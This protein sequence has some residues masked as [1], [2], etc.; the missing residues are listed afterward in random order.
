M[1]SKVVFIVGCT[2]CG[3]GTLTREL[4]VR[5]GGEIVSLDSM[6]VYRRMDIGTAKPSREAREAIPHHLIDL[7]EPSEE[8]TVARYLELAETALEEIAARER[9]ILVV[10]GTFL[11][12]KALTS[13]MFDG[14]GADP[15]VRDRL[16]QEAKDLGP[17]AFHEQLRKVDPVAAERIHHNDQRRVVRALEIY[18]LTGSTISSLQQQW[19]VSA[20][21][22][23]FQLLGLRRDKEDQSHR[24]NERVRR[25]IEA[26]LVDEVRGLM[27][28]PEPLSAT[29]K[30]AVGYAEIIQHLEGDVSLADAIEMIKINTRQ[31]AKSQ[32]TWLKRFDAIDWVDLAPDATAKQLAD[33]LMTSSELPWS[34]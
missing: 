30:K 19:K 22:R 12:L 2:G 14:P 10:G 9:P 20:P 4:A 3:K 13:G 18:E 16:N 11:Y 23:G 6:K 7:V 31:F 5:C 29:A 15:V 8:F 34:A 28:E 21:D 17:E 24:I 1:K 26:G 25:M 32:R 27:D 33:D